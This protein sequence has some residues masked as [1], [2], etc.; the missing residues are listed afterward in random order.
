MSDEVVLVVKHDDQRAT[1][2]HYADDDARIAQ[3]LAANAREHR[4]ICAVKKNNEDSERKK[5][6]EKE[7]LLQMAHETD[8]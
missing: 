4:Q 7:S 6:Q 1:G 5:T 3:T 2:R 8:P